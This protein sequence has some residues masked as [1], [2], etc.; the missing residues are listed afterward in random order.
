MK[1]KKTGDLMESSD[2]IY[3][4]DMGGNNRSQKYIVFQL[5]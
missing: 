3:R 2:R 1:K 4:L 5:R